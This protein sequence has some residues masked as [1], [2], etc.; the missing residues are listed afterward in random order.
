MMLTSLKHFDQVQATPI[1]SELVYQQKVPY[2]V[3][4]QR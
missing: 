2:V 4:D 1:L 3:H